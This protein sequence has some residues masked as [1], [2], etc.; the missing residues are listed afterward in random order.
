[1]IEIEEKGAS[2]RSTLKAMRE[3]LGAEVFSKVLNALPPGDF[4]EAAIAGR[5]LAAS[6]YPIRV[7]RELY[8]AIAKVAPNERGIPRRISVRSAEDDMRGIY[9]YVARLLRAETLAGIAPR[10]LSTYFRGPIITIEHVE[11]GEASLRFMG[12]H[13]FDADLWEGTVSGC[14]TI[15]R[16]AGHRNVRCE[17]MPLSRPEDSLVRLTWAV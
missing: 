5:V 11:Q 7:H 15:M 14:E 2:L 12:F 13:G 1:M 16:M 8:A 17:R 4:R 6:W 3:E 10:V 9:A